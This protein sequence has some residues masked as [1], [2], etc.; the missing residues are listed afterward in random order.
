MHRLHRLHIF[1]GNH[2]IDVRARLQMRNPWATANKPDLQLHRTA[3][4]DPQANR[5]GVLKHMRTLG[6]I[7]E[8]IGVLLAIPF[9]I[10]V[11]YLL[12]L[13][14][15]WSWGLLLFAAGA[16]L[17]GVIMLW[18]AVIVEPAPAASFPLVVVAHAARGLAASAFAIAAG[19]VLTALFQ[20]FVLSRD[21][22]DIRELQDFEVQLL[23]FKLLLERA[24]GLDVL[25]GI[26]VLMVGLS[27]V[28]PVKS[29]VQRT[30]SARRVVSFIYIVM[31]TL[32]SFTFFAGLALQPYEISL[33]HLELMNATFAFEHR[34]LDR[35]KSLVAVAWIMDKLED[36]ASPPI[37][38][39]LAQRLA[40]YAHGASDDGGLD[41]V[42]WRI[43][44]FKTVLY[45]SEDDS[46]R[47][48]RH[49]RE[50]IAAARGVDEGI[51]AKP[52]ASLRSFI[53]GIFGDTFSG[54]KAE[55]EPQAW[56]YLRVARTIERPGEV[57]PNWEDAPLNQA[58]TAAIE[59]L[60]N[61]LAEKIGGAV[62]GEEL[63]R[64]FVGEL[65]QAVVTPLWDVVLPLD[66]KDEVSARAF[67]ANQKLD[68]AALD[69]SK[70][71]EIPPLP[72]N[73]TPQ[74]TEEAGHGTS[75]GFG[76]SSPLSVPFG[77]LP[78]WQAFSGPTAFVYHPSVGTPEV[79]TG[80][81][82]RFR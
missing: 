69:W 45:F 21:Q 68:R 20:A 82:F 71:A 80:P 37:P 2:E 49:K 56:H 16:G 48:E 35:R 22:L 30:L 50:A 52:L 43:A 11:F 9:T 36:P 8:A 53:G 70:L 60:S 66:I 24:L 15:T 62:T 67:V 55:S 42:A 44:G 5:A 81:S 7:G 64:H 13:V 18:V 47:E 34:Y 41:S 31:L 4:Y 40:E 27:V 59:L 3:A 17:A 58:Y 57:P 75:T 54:L 63:S 73:P 10:L 38:P 32:T 14:V 65:V 39:D 23:Y 1:I 72:Q 25:A 77:A 78:S 19:L 46:R 26:L 79:Y 33:R 76:A 61:L 74:P 51:D 28:V 12:S 29:L 6:K